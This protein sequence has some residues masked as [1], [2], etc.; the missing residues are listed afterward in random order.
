MKVNVYALQT[1]RKGSKSVKNKNT[2]DINGKPL[3]RHPVDKAIKSKLIKSVFISTDIESVIQNKEKIDYSTIRRPDYLC[4]DNS[5][6][7]DTMIHGLKEIEKAKKEK[8]DFLVVLLGNSLGSP[9]NEIDKA[10][11][12]LIKNKQ[13]DSVQTVSEFNM[14]N[15]LRS[16]KIKND[17]LETCVDQKEIEKISILKNVNDKKSAGDVY[18]ANGSFFI[19]KREVLLNKKGLLP[20]PWLGYKIKPWIQ[21]VNMEIDAYWQ[22]FVLKEIDNEYT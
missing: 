2:M 4:K 16:F 11:D 19:C 6:H 12:F 9:G 17:N 15:P 18:F 20:Y 1:A 10:V 13:Y 8:V 5:S 7:H 14:F 3:Y 22:S 21:K